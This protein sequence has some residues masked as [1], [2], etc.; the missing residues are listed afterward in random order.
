MATQRQLIQRRDR[1]IA[2]AVKAL[3]RAHG[4]VL[5]AM[6]HDEE[7][8]LTDKIG[9]MTLAMA[10]DDAQRAVA[11]MTK[12]Q[13]TARLRR[14]DADRQVREWEQRVRIDRHEYSGLLPDGSPHDG[15]DIEEE[16][17]T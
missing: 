14:R 16:V 9:G 17:R 2:A 7:V 12:G 1:A 5:D 10:A 8:R 11:R 6:K 15:A 13:E 3:D 4:L